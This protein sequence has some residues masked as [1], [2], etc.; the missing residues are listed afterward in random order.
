MCCGGLHTQLSIL[1]KSPVTVFS[2]SRNLQVFSKLN[3]SYMFD[4]HSRILER[5][6]SRVGTN[7]MVSI[8]SLRLS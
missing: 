1:F 5:R 4:Q 8:S 3:V 2:S 7:H 6:T